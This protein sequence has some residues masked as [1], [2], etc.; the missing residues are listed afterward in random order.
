MEI[1]NFNFEQ[2]YF[3]L[4]GLNVGCDIDSAQL[5]EKFMEMQRQ[6]HPDRYASASDAVRR[7]AVQI[8]AHVNGAQQTLSDPLKRAEYCLQLQ[9]ISTDAETDAKMDT[10]FLMQQMELRE[11]LEEV[12]SAADPYKALDS[13]RSEIDQL[14]DS[15]STQVSATIID[16]KFDD[17]RD[18][19]RRWQFLEKLSAEANSLEAQLDDA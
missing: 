11:S 15:T 9:G 16:E 12:A 17:A 3:D 6:F 10:M 1:D 5:R 2:S 8:T 18:L 13:V 19:V 14:I 4:F 7:R